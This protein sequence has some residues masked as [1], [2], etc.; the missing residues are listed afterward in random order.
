MP[1]AVDCVS[2]QASFLFCLS[3]IFGKSRPF[4]SG[5][6]W[7]LHMQLSVI[8]RIRFEARQHTALSRLFPRATCASLLDF[9]SSVCA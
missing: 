6:G 7:L 3:H 2:V 8:S 5:G 9:I 4:E 1:Y